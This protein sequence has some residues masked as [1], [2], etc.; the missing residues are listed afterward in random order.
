[1]NNYGNGIHG[2]CFDVE[3]QCSILAES[4]ECSKNPDFMI[5]KE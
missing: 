2:K 1:M 5:G 4:G 3:K